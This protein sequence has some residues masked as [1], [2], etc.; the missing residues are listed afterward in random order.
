M[1]RPLQV[2]ALDWTADIPVTRA[3][4]RFFRVSP[5]RGDGG[6]SRGLLADIRAHFDSK[7]VTIRSCVQV[8]AL[9]W[10]RDSR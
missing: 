8:S 3:E 7:I 10:G 5:R 1:T 6:D 9:G 4:S 2:T